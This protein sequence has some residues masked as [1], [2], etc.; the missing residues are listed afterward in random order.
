MRFGISFRASEAYAPCA[1]PRSPEPYPAWYG[2]LAGFFLI[3]GV[4]GGGCQF[5]FG[6]A[7]PR[8]LCSCRGCDT[9]LFN[10][11]FTG[12]S[13]ASLC[14]HGHEGGLPRKPFFGHR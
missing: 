11:R 3:R 1:R 10:V 4:D 5:A 12:P 9:D 7:Q 2:S 6:D 13:T 14:R 8:S